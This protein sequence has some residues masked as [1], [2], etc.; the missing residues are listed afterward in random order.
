MLP[1]WPRGRADLEAEHTMTLSELLSDGY[2]A[3]DHN[4][5]GVFLAS[6]G[7]PVI[8][9]VAA[10][11]G[12]GGR[13]DKD[14]RFFANLAVGFGLVAVILEVL[15]IVIARVGFGATIMDANVLLLVGGPVALALGLLGVRLVFPL[16]E[17]GSARTAR[18]ALLFVLLVIG[19]I[20][21]FSQFRGWGI[22]FFG[23]IAQL[24]ALGLLAWFLLRRLGRRAIG[25]GEVTG[26]PRKG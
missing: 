9:T 12:K 2:A 8:G 18:A 6:V 14:G 15:V 21:F 13:S 26:P 3:V 10:W 4:A 19:I 17:L 11:I 22:V 7:V 16:S 5:L 25:R 20:W 23:S 24:A 1:A